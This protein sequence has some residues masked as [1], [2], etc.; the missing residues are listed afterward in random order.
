MVDLVRTG[1]DPDELAR[2]FEPTGQS[3]RAVVAKSRQKDGRHEAGGGA[4]LAEPE[5]DEVVRLRRKNKQIGLERDILSKAAAWFARET[6][7]LPARTGCGL[8]ISPTFRR[9]QDSCMPPSCSMPAAARSSAGRWPTTCVPGRPDWRQM[10]RLPLEPLRGTR[11]CRGSFTACAMIAF[12]RE[13]PL[14]GIATGAIP[15]NA[16]K[17]LAAVPGRR[18]Q[19]RVGRGYRR[20]R[21][22]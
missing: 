20:F 1:H 17:G 4:G 16:R 21:V 10:Q 5:R 13:R 12:D 18:R 2:E 6:G 15:G 3:I 7:T 19:G 22:G 14:V 9:T 11:A 8:P